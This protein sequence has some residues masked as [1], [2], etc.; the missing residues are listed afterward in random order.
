MTDIYKNKKVYLFL[1]IILILVLPIILFTSNFGIGF[2]SNISQWS[3]LGSFFGGVY[4]PVL[5]ILTLSVIFMQ[6]ILMSKQTKIQ[7]KQL[8]LQSH[9]NEIQLDL[10]E[11]AE[12]A[13]LS[14]N[15]DYYSELVTQSLSFT[16]QTD[17]PSQSITLKNA[18]EDAI[19][20]Y[21]TDKAKFNNDQIMYKQCLSELWLNWALVVGNIKYIE[22]E[23]RFEDYAEKCMQIE[24][25]K[26]MSKLG[27]QLCKDLDL[28]L[29]A[30]DHSLS[31]YPPLFLDYDKP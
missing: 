18:L 23:T 30:T 21:K 7:N 27:L 12:I 24:C 26:V 14:K 9:Q 29:I 31:N 17:K 15:I 10:I 25:L 8:N 6:T 4:T 3:E 2:Y 13:K 1:F 28:L 22:T 19:N 16:I 11:R 5:S 20:I